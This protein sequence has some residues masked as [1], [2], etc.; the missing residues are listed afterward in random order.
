MP[1]FLLKSCAAFVFFLATGCVH[2]YYAPNTLHIPTLQKRHDA[3]LGAGYISGV[4]HSGYEIKSV[5]SPFPHTA[6]MLNHF[7][8]RQ[9]LEYKEGSSKIRLT[10][11]AIGGY[12]PF[13]DGSFSVFTG[14]GMGD[15]RHDYGNEAYA[16]LAVRRLFFQPSLTLQS[17]FFNFGMGIRIMHLNFPSGDIDYRISSTVEG[18]AEIEIIKKIERDAPFWLTEFGAQLAIRL[19]PCVFGMYGVLSLHDYSAAYQFDGTS[20]GMNISLN[21][22]EIRN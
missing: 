15:S 6:V 14:Y 16:R 22:H 7:D 4:G 13:R 10:E 21:L 17:D 11:G 8:L 2:K 9:K 12:M 20:I 5:Y 18:Q 3:S 1:S 19:K